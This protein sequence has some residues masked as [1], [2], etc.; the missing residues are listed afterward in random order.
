MTNTDKLFL[1]VDFGTQG[2]R[3]GVVN[4]LGSILQVKEVKYPIHFPHP[5]WATQ[6]SDDWWK[7]FKEA[8]SFCMEHLTIEE[9]QLVKAI[10]LC[11]TSSTM[12]PVDKDGNALKEAMMWMDIRSK[13]HAK[14]INSVKHPV[15]DF[16]GG[17]VSPEWLIPKLHWFKEHE[18]DIYNHAYKIVEQLDFINYKLTGRWVA[19]KCN[20]VCKWN[21]IDGRGFNDQYMA[22]IGL[23]DYKDK[24]I[25]DIVPIGSLIGYLTDEVAEE[26]GLQSIP[27]I[28]GGIDAH[29]GM[30]GMGVVTPGKMATI[31]GTSF[32]QL[33][34]TDA[35]VPV[36]GIWGPYNGAM[37]EGLTLLE[38]GQISAGSIIK[39]YK[40][41]FG[42]NGPE[43][44][45]IMLEEAKNIPIG[46][47]GVRALDF[48]QG[49]RTPYKD[50]FATGA[51]YGLTLNHTR[52]HIH[53]AIMEA[54]AFGTKNIINNYEKNGIPVNKIVGCGGVTNDLLWMKIIADVTGKEIIVNENTNYGTIL[55]CAL[56]CANTTNCYATLEE[57]AKHM[58][59][60][61]ETIYPDKNA[62]KLYAKPYREYLDLYLALKQIRKNDLPAKEEEP[63]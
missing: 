50:N 41:T 5:G 23:E 6:N 38:G 11:A 15:L 2:V 36:S 24:I 54:V 34:F 21:Y 51:F 29:I 26:L 28:E 47:G 9:K 56:L 13:E 19:S 31:M 35:Y 4:E 58:T 22:Q 7:G 3:V 1:G 17:E 53:R 12:L 62:T 37:I 14:T 59:H 32:V 63:V 42:L 60:E 57:A 46:A 55:G 52:A 16:C 10:A 43:A 45:K 30:I 20:A 61:K 18:R 49:N 39:W 25:T 40:S 48:F 8:L 27:V 33:L 44:Y